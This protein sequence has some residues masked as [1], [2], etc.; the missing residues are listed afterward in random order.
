MKWLLL[1]LTVSG[2]VSSRELAFGTKLKRVRAKAKTTQSPV[3]IDWKNFGG[4]LRDEKSLK[5]YLPPP[6]E[7]EETVVKNDLPASDPELDV[8]DLNE[9][10]Q[11]D[12]EAPAVIIQPVTPSTPDTF[13]DLQ[14]S[15]PNEIPQNN[16]YSPPVIQTTFDQTFS[17]VNNDISNEIQDIPFTTVTQ[18]VPFTQTFNTFES[19][20]QDIPFT[21]VG[22]DAPASNNDGCTTV[23]E[24]IFEQ[25]EEQT[26]SV[27]NINSC[28]PQYSDDCVKTLEDICEDVIVTEVQDFCSENLV[29]VCND[30]VEDFTRNVC[31]F[32]NDTKCETEYS[33]QL[34]DECTYET[35]FETVCSEGYLISYEDECEGEGADRVCKKTPK[36][37]EKQ[38]RKVPR[39][40]GKC[41]KVPVLRPNKCE[42]IE[43]VLCKEEP[44]QLTIKRCS[45]E[46]RPICRQQPVEVVKTICNTV[47]RETCSLPTTEVDNN[48][49]DVPQNV[50]ETK[51]VP[52][53]R[54]IE[55]LECNNGRY[56]FLPSTIQYD[57]SFY[58][59]TF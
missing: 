28:S 36:Y 10:P 31:S 5:G 6:V 40:E 19:G 59:T 35:K 41:K 43:R 51:L 16:P 58:T 20:V 4:F 46:N 3:L 55:R 7:D 29:N 30:V 54:T 21:V 9:I 50:C 57:D 15:Y 37:P 34:K 12:P 42:Q 39:V 18:D 25:I 2:L 1:V 8:P 44:Y 38:C 33:E 32:V 48:C 13:V 22:Q 23:T 56:D 27:V 53:T 49:Q 47:Q 17:T 26:C 24:T 52:F 14:N 45:Y 11:T